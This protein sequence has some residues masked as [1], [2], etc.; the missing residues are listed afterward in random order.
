M[1]PGELDAV[2]VTAVRAV[3]GVV[4]SGAAITWED[5]Y[6]SP[7]AVRHRLPAQAIAEEVAAHPGVSHVET[8]GPGLLAV[9]LAVPGRIAE[10]IT[11]DERY[12]TGATIKACWADFP[13]TFD[14]PGFRVRFAHERACAVLRR[15]PELGVPRGDAAAL[16]T[17][18]ERKLLGLL[19]GFDGHRKPV[20][21]LERIADAYHDVHEAFREEPTP[22]HGARV[23]LAGAVRVTLSNGLRRLGETPRERL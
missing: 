10:A 3:T 7:V 2:I 21:Q 9:H 14:N 22:Q 8:R 5:T 23:L 6:V 4:V 11:R 18:A 17:P 20:L 16:T 13:R 15:A 12:G 19:A 1:T